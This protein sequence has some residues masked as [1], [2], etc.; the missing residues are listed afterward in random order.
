MRKMPQLKDVTTDQ[1]NRGLQ[2]MLDY[3]RRSA[4]RF[5][6]TPQ[7]ID[8]SLYFGFGESQVSTIYTSLNQYYVVLQAAPQFFAQPAHPQVHLRAL[9]HR[10]H[11]SR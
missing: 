11:R 10:R 8:N 9:Q 4:A 2:M 7:L 3:D 6:I 5:G 1:Q